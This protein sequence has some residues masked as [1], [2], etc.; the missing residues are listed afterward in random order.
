MKNNTKEK[1]KAQNTKRKKDTK[2]KDINDTNKE[3]NK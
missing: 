3:N 1:N 2:Q